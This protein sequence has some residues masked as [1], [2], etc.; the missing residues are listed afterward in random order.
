MP[1]DAPNPLLSGSTELI[2]R[3]TTAVIGYIPK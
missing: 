2:S 3:D 1:P